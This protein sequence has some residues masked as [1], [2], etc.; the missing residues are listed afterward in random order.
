MKKL[1]VLI[2]VISFALTIIPVFAAE[3][4]ESEQAEKPSFFQQASDD[5]SGIKGTGSEKSATAI[6]Q[7]SGDKI[8]AG[9][10]DAKAL[11]LRNN[12][13]ELQKRM[14]GKNIIM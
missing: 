1:M 8:E 12:K 14:L 9:S 5:I 13:A 6:F 4:A 3:K 10:P 2:I 7:E 11:S